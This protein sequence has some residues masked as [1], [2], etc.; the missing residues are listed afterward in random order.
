MMKTTL[1]KELLIKTLII[2]TERLFVLRRTIPETKVINGKKQL[3]RW[4]E[5]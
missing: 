1:E 4:Y 5:E 2:K 3:R